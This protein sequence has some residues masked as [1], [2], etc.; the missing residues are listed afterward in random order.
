MGIQAQRRDYRTY[1]LDQK[2]DSDH[3]QQTGKHLNEQDAF[4]H[5]LALPKTKSGKRVRGH[6]RYGD[7]G[8]RCNGCQ[9]G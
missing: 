2:K 5:I 9:L 6:G 3:G 1:L 7:G 4:Q 8:E